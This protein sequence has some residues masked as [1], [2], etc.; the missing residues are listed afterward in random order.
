ME[1]YRDN[2]LLIVNTATQCG[3]VAQFEEL[4]NLHQKYK[5]EKFAI[6]GFPCNQFANQEP[7]ANETMAATCKINYGVTFL[8]S[9]KILVNGENTHPVFS[10]LKEH[11][12]AGLFGRKIRWNFTKFLVST[13]AKT[14]KRYPPAKKPMRIEKDIIAFLNQ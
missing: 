5:N 2:V 7:E 12:Q 11:S 14:I 9:E 13:D 6:I 1:Q 4:E 3:L 10:Y 8:L